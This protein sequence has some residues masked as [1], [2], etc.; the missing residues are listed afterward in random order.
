VVAISIGQSHLL[1]LKEAG[2]MIP[3]TRPGKPTHEETIRKWIKDGQD[4]VFLA[5]KRIGNRLFTS[6]E[7]LQDFSDACTQ[8]EARDL[9]LA[10]RP[11]DASESMRLLRERHRI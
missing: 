5:F 2:E 1:T 9:E 6:V 11:S 10:R 3:G 8:R 7:A 4:G